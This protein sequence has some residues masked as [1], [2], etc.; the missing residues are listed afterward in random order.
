MERVVSGVRPTGR[1]HIGN[2]FGAVKNF[3]GM[4]EENVERFFF[5]ADY[6]SLT[7]HPKPE[8]LH[9]NVK[10][11]LVTYLACGLDP[12]Q[13]TLYAQSDLPEIPELFLVLNMLAY[14]G[15]LERSTTFKEKAEKQTENINAGLLTYPVLM[16]AD[17]LIHRA[18]RVPVGKDQEQHLEMTRTYANRFNHNY[19]VE[20]FPEPQAFSFSNKLVKIPSLNGAGKM[21]KSE[22]EKNTVFLGETPDEIRKKVKRAKS[23]SGPDAPNQPISDDIQHLFTLM[24]AVSAPETLQFYKDQYAQANIRY[25]D[26]KGQ[27]AEDIITFTSPIRERMEA[28]AADDAYLQKVLRMGAEKARASA[29]QTIKDVR[30][31]I[32]IKSF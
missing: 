8:D 4:Q 24:E 3:V 11:I 27:L 19:G 5:I 28:Y 17:I 14:K 13:T 12:E 26:M 10:E 20:Y 22:A 18:Q 30:E 9:A 32:G 31:I 29:S 7:T 1:L 25:G 21:G 2:Y 23:D 15:E 16:A 6:H